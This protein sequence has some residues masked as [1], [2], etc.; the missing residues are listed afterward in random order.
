MGGSWHEP[1]DLPQGWEAAPEFSD[2]R[3]RARHLVRTEFGEAKMWGWKDPRTCLTLP[4][5]RR[6]VPRTRYVICVRN[7]LETA[8]S[9]E[10][11]YDFTHGVEL[12]LMYILPRLGTAPGAERLILSYESALDDPERTLERLAAFV[13]RPKLA[14]KPQIQ[15]AAD[16]FIERELRHHHCPLV[17]TTDDGELAFQ[18]KA[19]YLA[20][21]LQE[22]LALTSTGAESL[23]EGVLEPFAD[24]AVTSRLACEALE[25]AATEAGRCAADQGE[26]LERLR[27]ELVDRAAASAA[28]QVELDSAQADLAAQIATLAGGEADRERE[29]I[30]LRAELE[31]GGRMPR[32]P[33]PR[34]CKIARASGPS[35]TPENVHSDQEVGL[36]KLRQDLRAAE[37]A[38][39][40]Q[41]RALAAAHVGARQ[42]ERR[43]S[44]S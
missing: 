35:W 12:W 20:L 7:P 10:S 24:S 8:A 33:R 17:D 6:V 38:A 40:E 43:R 44:R 41:G 27:R 34:R 26:E 37:E 15:A 18:A 39:V 13:G 29:L 19:L 9:L 36:T 23:L 30:A 22:R 1:P 21:V 31:A 3:R 5:W 28:R 32:A 14:R 11:A 4:F 42:H 16:D 25:A 2:L